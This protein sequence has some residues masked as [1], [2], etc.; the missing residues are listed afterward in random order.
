MKK[1]DYRKFVIKTVP[2]NDD[3]AS[4]REV[5]A[6]RYRRQQE[7]KKPLPDLIL[8][9]GGI[10]QL[11]AAAQSLEELQIINQPLASIAKREEILFVYGREKE[12]VV[13]DHHSPV[14]HL[15]QQIRDEAHRFAV[16]FHRAR[17]AGRQLTS[18]LLQVDGVGER[19][20]QKLL[21]HFG[22][23]SRIQEARAEELTQVVTARQA[24]AIVAHFGTMTNQGH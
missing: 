19:T 12:P 13:I 20:A 3:F 21:R 15:I 6:R 16:G 18:E 8:V 22:S 23:L 4:M 11:H 7:E 24:H 5:V 2:S 17:R 14:L 1:A 9:D 10:G